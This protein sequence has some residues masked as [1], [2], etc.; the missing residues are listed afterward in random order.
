M[1]DLLAQEDTVRRPGKPAEQLVRGAACEPRV[2]QA[3][4]VA[5]GAGVD[6]VEVLE[7][8]ADVGVAMLQRRRGG[9]A[10]DARRRVAQAGGEAGCRRRAE[11]DVGAVGEPGVR[12]G[13]LPVGRVEGRRGD[14][15]A[16]R[17][18]DQR[19]GARD[20]GALLEHAGS[21]GLPE[22]A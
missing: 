11:H 21:D 2:L 7:V 22:V 17:Q 12:F 6:T 19:Q 18:G 3:R 4:S 5:D 10:G 16:G 14:G 9:H 8:T 1:D 15:E 20:R 13:L